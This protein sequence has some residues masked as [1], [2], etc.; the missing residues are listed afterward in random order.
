M[1]DAPPLL[2]RILL[3]TII[4][5]ETE[6]LDLQA[7]VQELEEKF[8]RA[9]EGSDVPDYEFKAKVE[10]SGIN[11]VPLNV[12]SIKQLLPELNGAELKLLWMG[13]NSFLRCDD[14]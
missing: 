7:V 3:S 11:I 1:N 8:I 12:E 4:M 10:L 14:F 9:H 6:L 2:S 13:L 5:T